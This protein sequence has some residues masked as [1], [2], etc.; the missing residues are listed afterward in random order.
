MQ[1]HLRQIL[2]TLD[3]LVFNRPEIMIG[4]AASKFDESGR[5]TD[6][7]TR[8]LVRTQLTAFAE[9]VRSNRPPQL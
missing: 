6:E 3:A 2:V 8:T 1:Y 4:T 9:F 5:L 7:P